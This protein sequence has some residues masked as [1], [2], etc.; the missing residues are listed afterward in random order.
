MNAPIR[1][2]I[3]EALLRRAQEHV[4]RGEATDLDALITE[5]LQ[6]YL[7][8]HREHLQETFVREDIDWGL[9]GRD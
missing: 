5:A 4:A 6:R 8:S 1:T 2:A 9:H 3:P 7:D